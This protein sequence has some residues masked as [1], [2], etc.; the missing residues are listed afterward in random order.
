MSPPVRGSVLI[1]GLVAPSEALVVAGAAVVVSAT[2]VVV[3][4][5]VEVADTPALPVDV[6]VWVLVRV[7]VRE[8]LVAELVLVVDAVVL[9][10][11]VVPGG[12]VAFNE[13]GQ[14]SAGAGMMSPSPVL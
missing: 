2:L 6:R 4:V 13:V 5:V 7:W 8:L 3:L 14:P 11:L 1:A 9:D 12:G 10:P